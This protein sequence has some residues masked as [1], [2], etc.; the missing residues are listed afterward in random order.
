MRAVSNLR[1]YSTKGELAVQVSI[2]LAYARIIDRG[3]NVRAVSGKRMA[4]SGGVRYKRRGYN[5]KGS[6]FMDRGFRDWAGAGPRG[7]KAPI[8]PS[9]V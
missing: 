7:G 2:P 6:R 5:I 8:K 4:W 1:N 3:G 9:W